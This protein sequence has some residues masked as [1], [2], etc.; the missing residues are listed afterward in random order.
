[1][2]PDCGDGGRASG[3]DPDSLEALVTA[4]RLKDERRTGWQLRGVEEPE[5]VAAHSWG[6]CLLC[7]R[8]ADEAGVDPDRALG[9]AVVHD[10]GEAT[11]G[12][13]PTRADPDADTVP[14]AEKARREREAVAA[15]AVGFDDRDLLALWEAYEGREEPAAR[16]VKDMDLVDMCAQALAYERGGR[17]DPGETDAFG[18][19]DR[20]DEFF[21]TAESRLSTAVG[22]RLFEAVRERYRTARD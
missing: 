17:Y 12:D 3:D 21:A 4:Y 11:V 18:A 2:V 14:D 10:I 8:Y 5:S 13:I 16:F 6:V 22:R 1:M 9:M 7:L 20:L 19:Y 15:L